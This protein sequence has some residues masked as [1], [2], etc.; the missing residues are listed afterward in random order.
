[1]SDQENELSEDELN[2]LL[3]D[4]ES[5]AGSSSSSAAQPEE[6]GGEDIEAF[7]ASLE[8]ESSAAAATPAKKTKTKP[9]DDDLAAQFAELEQLDELPAKREPTEPAKKAEK[10]AKK[11]KKDKKAEKKAAK[12]GEV[13]VVEKERSRGFVFAL[14]ALKWLALTL[15]IAVLA[16]VTGAFLSRW[17]SAGW[18]VGIVSLT[19]ALGL[20]AL[21]YHFTQKRGRYIWW[22]TGAGVVLTVLLTLPMP[23]TAATSLKKY[24]H[25]PM[26]MVA[27]VAG[28]DA[29][30]FLVEAN[31]S[32]AN[33]VGGLIFPT[34]G[35]AIAP[36]QLG[37]D[38]P[39]DRQ[40]LVDQPAPEAQPTPAAE[41]PPEGG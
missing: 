40:P 10:K 8:S 12:E 7:L 32:V 30:H 26:S 1:M 21:V 29:D 18:L 9:A 6:E 20:P 28:W 31:A 14:A 24:G 41:P 25:W 17:I 19:F 23:E 3:S 37:T 36:R 22:A 11:S 15:P 39:L 4:L 35:D 34:V 2:A 38:H 33:T 27:D 16:W 13:Q 5:R